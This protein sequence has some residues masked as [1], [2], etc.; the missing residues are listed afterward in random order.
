MKANYFYPKLSTS[1]I[2]KNIFISIAVSFMCFLTS[3][4][5][6]CQKY[7]NP[8]PSPN[9][10]KEKTL[11]FLKTIP[12]IKLKA[13]YYNISKPI[14]ETVLSLQSNA[15][16]NI[17]DATFNYGRILPTTDL[18]KYPAFSKTKNDFIFCSTRSRGV[19]ATALSLSL[20]RNKEK[21]TLSEGQWVELLFG[22]GG[23]LQGLINEANQIYASI[24]GKS[25]E[26]I[27]INFN[28]KGLDSPTEE[29]ELTQNHPKAIQVSE[30]QKVIE[31]N[32]KPL[33]SGTNSEPS[34][35][36]QKI[37]SQKKDEN[38][39]K[40]NS[41]NELEV[42]NFVVNNNPVE[43]N[44]IDENKEESI[45]QEQINPELESSLTT[46]IED[47]PNTQEKQDLKS[48]AQITENE[49]QDNNSTTKMQTNQ[50]VNRNLNQTEKEQKKP[51]NF[52]TDKGN[53]L[54][55]GYSSLLYFD[56]DLTLDLHPNYGYFFSNNFV[57]GYSIRHL[58]NLSLGG[59]DE[60]FNSLG[61][62]IRVY[63]GKSQKGR[64]FAQLG[65]S[66]G[67]YDFDF[68]Y[69]TFSYNARAGYAWFLNQNTALELSIFGEEFTDGDVNLGLG[70]GYQIHFSK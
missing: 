8:N 47:N 33:V 43:D 70:L 37:E 48:D 63:G 53:W 52:P 6:H 2:A 58:Q 14:L 27:G 25:F 1:R 67:I 12:E 39:N 31:Y 46:N 18:T 41:E 23:E 66:V 24:S 17:S 38:E 51:Q 56:E 28:S 20:L 13:D 61:L 3:S 59:S 26:D 44:V 4:P 65:G 29:S 22:E 19:E 9:F 5:L 69:P 60:F 50:L 42:D 40:T 36:E 57:F 32:H 35:I 54:Y 11:T 45:R 68:E 21:E 55:G 62:Y 49:I 15:G 7:F 30:V 64:I 34:Q 10:D 16:T